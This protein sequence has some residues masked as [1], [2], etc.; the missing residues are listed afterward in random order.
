MELRG[1]TLWLIGA[2]SGIGAALAPA[3]AAEGAILA[4]SARREPELQ[5][6]ADACPAAVRPLVRPL[7]ATD[8]AQ[9]DR[10]CADLIQ[11][12]G[13]LD[14]LFYNA[15]TTSQARA[16]DFDSESAL[17]QADVTYLGL[18][19]AVG[20]ALPHMLARGEGQIVGTGSVAG[21]AGFPR[22][23]VYSSA[24]NA[25]NAFLQSMR[26]ELKD[27]GIGVV[28]VNPGFVKTPLTEHNTFPMPFLM[29]A[30]EAAATIVK[31]LLAGD[32]E[33]HFPKRLTWPAKVYT[34]L[35][36]PVYEFVSRKVL[37]RM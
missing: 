24:K 27:R 28:T 34:A 15:T 36:R 29:T 32:D 4:L 5:Q 17:Q 26:I 22:S 9:V 37:R 31:G 18:I 8:K 35:P 13:K 11:A 1:R 23:P 3:L 16:T 33:I 14:I 20:A 30:D 7:D 19:R 12:W 10:V 6:V 21:Y 25:V 2:S